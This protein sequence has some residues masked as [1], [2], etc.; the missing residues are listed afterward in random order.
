MTNSANAPAPLV[1]TIAHYISELI[2]NGELPPG[3]RVNEAEMAERFGVSR[4][5]VREA[6]AILSSGFIVDVY[7]RRGA[8]VA[9]MDGETVK[10]LC[11]YAA[12]QFANLTRELQRNIHNPAQLDVFNPL[13]EKVNSLAAD[14]DTNVKKFQ[15]ACLAIET[16]ACDMIQNRFLLEALSQM[17]LAVRRV[18][19]LAFEEPA[20]ITKHAEFLT[21]T[22]E[23]VRNGTL[24]ANVDK[25]FRSHYEEMWK[26]LVRQ[27]KIS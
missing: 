20:A 3:A 4:G 2:L 7:P 18:E 27:G 21:N 16:Q 15:D 26:Q 14:D 5:P 13:V 24:D 1:D 11:E 8:F 10:Q 6:I 9:D 17:G 22:V 25:Y 23:A 12:Y 19:A